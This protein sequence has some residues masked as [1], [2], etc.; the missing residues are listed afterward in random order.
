MLSTRLN[1]VKPHKF[2]LDRTNWCIYGA[3]FYMYDSIENALIR[4]K[5]MTMLEEP[6]WQGKDKNCVE[7]ESEEFGCKVASSISV[8]D[9]VIIGD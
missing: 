2:V 1:H 8:P 7:L 9:M 3:F 4:S 6:E 5:V